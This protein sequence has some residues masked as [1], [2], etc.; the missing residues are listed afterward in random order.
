MK[1]GQFRFP[2]HPIIFLQI[3][4]ASAKIVFGHIRYARLGCHL[5]LRTRENTLN[6]RIERLACFFQSVVALVIVS[7]NSSAQLLYEF[8]E[9]GTESILATL[10]L[11]SLP[12]SHSE[13]VGLMFTPAGDMIFGMGPV[14]IGTFDTSSSFLVATVEELPNGEL[15]CTGCDNPSLATW[16]IDE[17]PPVGDRFALTFSLGSGGILRL[18]DGNVEDI[19]SSGTWT[20]RIPEPTACVLTLCAFCFMLARRQPK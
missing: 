13:I 5:S 2:K 12:A 8:E 1:L 19:G 6:R 14:Y 20:R 4:A 15:T 17:D 7:S 11:S 18:L 16:F 9:S 10:E 3:Y